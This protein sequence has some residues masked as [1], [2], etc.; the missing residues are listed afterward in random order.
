MD[1]I[2]TPLLDIIESIGR[3]ELHLKSIKTYDSEYVKTVD[4]ALNQA[5]ELLSTITNPEDSIIS[6]L[7]LNLKRL[8]VII[9]L[10]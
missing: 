4:K 3:Q 10:L 5:K 1:D 8:R 9:H 2:E 7:V 6:A